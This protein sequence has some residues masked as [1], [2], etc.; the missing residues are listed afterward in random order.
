MIA[1]S[2]LSAKFAA[3]KP[4]AAHVATGTADQQEKWNAVYRRCALTPPQAVLCGSFSRRM[5]I[6][7]S[8][9]VWCGDCA[10]HCPILA[11][12]AEASSCIEVRFLNRDE[13][14]E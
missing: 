3:A 12:I 7:V 4:F 13:H 5:H 9:G 14:M 10:H 1:S 2:L 11:R 6:L 8:S